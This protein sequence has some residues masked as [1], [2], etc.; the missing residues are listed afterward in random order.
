M[1][2]GRSVDGTVWLF[3]QVAEEGCIASTYFKELINISTR[4]K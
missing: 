3:L 2:L 1:C 4:F